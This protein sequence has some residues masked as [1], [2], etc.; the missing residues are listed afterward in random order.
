M[1]R[2]YLEHK[3]DHP[4]CLFLIQVGDF[5][6]AFFEDAVLIANTLNLTLTSRDK[7]AEN[8]IPMAGVPIAAVESYLSLIH[9]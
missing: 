8:P 3:Q 7:K 9:I 2:Q 6:E 4:D 5:Y 1:L